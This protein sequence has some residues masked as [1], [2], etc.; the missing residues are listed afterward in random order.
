MILIFVLNILISFNSFGMEKED[1]GNGN[2]HSDWP[3][4]YRSETDA[5]LPKTNHVANSSTAIIAPPVISITTILDDNGQELNGNNIPTIEKKADD[6]ETIRRQNVPQDRRWIGNVLLIATLVGLEIAAGFSTH[7][8][9]KYYNQ[10]SINNFIKDICCQ[11][12]HKQ[13]LCSNV[14]W[15]TSQCFEYDLTC[16]GIDENK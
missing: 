8:L 11:F 7:A 14:T 9:T 6:L 13:A 4:Y 1:D 2:N 10:R 12:F 5:L 15:D 3:M 16:A